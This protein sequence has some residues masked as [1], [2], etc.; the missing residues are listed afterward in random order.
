VQS[1]QSTPIVGRSGGVIGVLS[2]HYRQPRRFR[3]GELAALDAAAV[4]AARWTEAS[5][6]LRAGYR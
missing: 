5:R 1:V 6:A 2:T 4:R 3:A